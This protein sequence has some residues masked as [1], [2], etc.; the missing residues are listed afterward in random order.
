M[1]GSS[2][3]AGELICRAVKQYNIDQVV[4]GRRSMGSFRRFFS[5][6]TSQYV[7]E[8]A[9]CNVVVVKLVPGPQEEHVD[10]AKVIQMEEEERIRRVEEEYHRERVE[11]EQ[12]QAALEKIHKLEEDERARRV[13]EDKQHNI[14]LYTFQDEL[15]QKVH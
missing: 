14:H 3:H 13:A 4:T 5:G 9:E 11:K 15:K 12:S 10:R 7:V 6:S 8:N 1:K 2:A